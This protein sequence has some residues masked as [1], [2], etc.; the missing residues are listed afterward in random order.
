MRGAISIGRRVQ[1]PLSELVKIDPRSIGVGLYQHD[2]KAKHLRQ[3]LDAV[4][5]SCVNFVGVDVNTASPALLRYVSGLNQLTAR[6]IFDHRCKNGPFRNREQLKEVPGVGEAT[7]VQAAGFLRIPDGDNPLD[8]TWIHPESYA[9]AERILQKLGSS[10]ATLAKEKPAPEQVIADETPDETPDGAPDAEPALAE[11]AEEATVEPAAE[12][13]DEPATTEPAPAVP[14]PT[15]SEPTEPTTAQA[16]PA[17]S[18]PEEET[19]A[20][21][22]I[23]EPTAAAEPTAAEPTPAE[24]TPAE[25]TAAE[26]A[27][28]EPVAQEGPVS[29]EGAAEPSALDALSAKVAKLDL[30][31]LSGEFGIGRLSLSDLLSGLTSPGRDPR[32]DLPAPLSRRGVMKLDDLKP[33]MELTGTVVNVV[34]FG[35]FVDVGVSDSG[36]VHISRL[37]DRYISDPHDAVS[38]G[39]MLHVWVVEIDK[40]RRRVSLTA[41][42]PGTEK[43]PAARRGKRPGRGKPAADG[44]G[45]DAARTKDQGKRTGGKPPRGRK[46]AGPRDRKPGGKRPQKGP[47]KGPPHRPKPKPKP[48]VPITDEMAEGKEAMRTFGDLLQFMQIKKTDE[49]GGQKKSSEEQQ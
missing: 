43:P 34:D 35:A 16:A 7:F 17:D 11:V 46:P 3:S 49:D 29:Q 2:V 5:E 9:S 47:P 23:T 1:D 44:E 18:L 25:P 40:S 31:E 45:P 41:I 33:G 24:S 27:A 21:P 37:A 30:D 4:V 6:R 28:S 12:S 14:T 19:P 13:V 32:D 26:P 36:L 48:L 39:D 38:I 15:A 8:A 42:E 22:A 10:V 20:E